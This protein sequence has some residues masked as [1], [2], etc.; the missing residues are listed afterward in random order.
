M[1][2]IAPTPLPWTPPRRAN[3]LGERKP[4]VPIAQLAEL[5]DLDLVRSVASRDVHSRSALEVLFRRHSEPLI[6]FI[7]RRL[8]NG[9]NATEEVEDLVHDTFVR[10]AE[11]AGTFRGDCP[12]R[13]WLFTLALNIG[14]SKRRRAVLERKIDDAYRFHRPDQD[15][16]Q[17][18]GVFDDT[19]KREL[20]EKVGLAVEALSAQERETFELYWFG[21]LTYAEISRLTGVSISAAKV[22][23]HRAL[24]QLGRKLNAR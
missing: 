7:Y 8:G 5:S 22:R 1:E 10:L 3:H 19:E 14:R 11:K 4:S 9:T 2:H 21:Q 20:W 16:A 12:F 17:Q 15:G 18:G 13:T 23:V 24:N 6:C